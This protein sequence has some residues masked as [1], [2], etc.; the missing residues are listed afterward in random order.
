MGCTLVEAGYG[1]TGTTTA[2]RSWQG[3]KFY[4]PARTLLIFPGNGSQTVLHYLGPQW[5]AQWP[6]TATVY[7][8]RFWEPGQ[9][10]QVVT[11]RIFP[12]MTSGIREA[13]VIDDVISSGATCR[14]ILRKNQPWIANTGWSAVVWVKQKSSAALRGYHTIFAAKEVG[15]SATKVTINSLSTLLKDRAIA[16][17]YAQR[18]FA[19][20]DEFLAILDEI[21][22]EKEVAFLHENIGPTH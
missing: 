14:A 11:E 6:H 1:P 18:N 12:H 21:G 4:D 7:A 16:C 5:L 8:K 10:P 13:V 17:F 20:P 3:W 19:K 9:N 22:A 2:I 15:T